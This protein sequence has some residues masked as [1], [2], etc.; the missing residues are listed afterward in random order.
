MKKDAAKLILKFIEL[1]GL[2][3]FLYFAVRLIAKEI[4]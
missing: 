4:F 3:A 1:I 2:I